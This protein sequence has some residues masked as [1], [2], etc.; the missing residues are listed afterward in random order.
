[1]TRKSR[2]VSPIQKKGRKSDKLS[3]PAIGAD[4]GGKIGRMAKGGSVKSGR[5]GCAQ[6]GHTK[7]TII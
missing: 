5:D 2:G 6:R 7:G 1:M 3:I 4:I